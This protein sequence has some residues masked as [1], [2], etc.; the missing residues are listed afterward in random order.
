MQVAGV[1]N[2][3]D[4]VSKYI[5]T[6]TWDDKIEGARVLEVDEVAKGRMEYKTEPSVTLWKRRFIPWVVD[7]D[8]QSLTN[9]IWWKQ[10]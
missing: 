6:G 1:I 9:K 10:N 4:G 3:A 5:V 8:F 7:D 2:N